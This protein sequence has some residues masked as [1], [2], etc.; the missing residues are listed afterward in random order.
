MISLKSC[1]T[2]DWSTDA[3]NS[4]LPSQEKKYIEKTLVI[5]NSNNTSQYYCFYC[6]CDQLNE[7]FQKHK[8]SFEL[9]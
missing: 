3:E 1:D 5:L 9:Y 7:F 6:I 8:S 4:A 2:K